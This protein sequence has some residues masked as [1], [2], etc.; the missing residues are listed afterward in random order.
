MIFIP[1]NFIGDIFEIKQVSGV[2]EKI[3]SFFENLWTILN[4]V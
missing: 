4:Q 1:L 2:F 3:C